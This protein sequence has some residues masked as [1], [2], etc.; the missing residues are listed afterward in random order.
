MRILVVEDNDRVAQFLLKGLS[1]EGY[2]IDRLS[3]GGEVLSATETHSYDLILLDVMLPERDGFTIT[4]DLRDRGCKLPI[5]LLTAKDE[6]SDRVQGLDAGADDYLAK[7][8]AFSELLAR[9]RALLR[10][11]ESPR[12]S[13]LTLADLTL[14]PATRV[15]TRA[16]KEINLTAKE[17][18]LLE[19]LLRN[20]GRV[21][22]RTNIT[23]HI[24]DINF[25]SGTNVV[26]VYI[27][28]LRKK[29]DDDVPIKL[30][31]T[32]RGVGY[33]MKDPR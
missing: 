18:A 4:R 12:E 26:D 3:R 32:V 30:I 1:E 24:W 25:D 6:V 29:L 17:F 16:D 13:Q 10:R 27:R 14:D 9:I 8:F 2:A 20:K 23:E 11:T 22:T 7:P 28:Y 21:L 31:H 15:V 5:L 33:I 19:F